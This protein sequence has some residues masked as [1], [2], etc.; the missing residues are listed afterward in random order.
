M[1]FF[2]PIELGRRTE[3]FRGI[4]LHGAK[5]PHS[6]RSSRFRSWC[7]ASAIYRYGSVADGEHFLE[8]WLFAWPG[9]RKQVWFVPELGK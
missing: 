5:R 7:R 2:S 1:R 8:E 3:V 4:P 6:L 9:K